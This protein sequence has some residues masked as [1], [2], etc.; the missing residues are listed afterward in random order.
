M[1]GL[2]LAAFVHLPEEMNGLPGVE[3]VVGFLRVPWR[4]PGRRLETAGPAGIHDQ[5]CDAGGGNDVVGLAWRR[6]F[7][8][9]ISRFPAH[10]PRRPR[11]LGHERVARGVQDMP[12]DLYIHVVEVLDVQELDLADD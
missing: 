3:M 6:P 10:A 8:G 7:P 4:G 1:I 9:F 11:E 2:A 5:R 12:V